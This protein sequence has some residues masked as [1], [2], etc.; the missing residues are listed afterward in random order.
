MKI[1]RKSSVS[2]ALV[3]ESVDV[4]I[5]KFHGC[6]RHTHRSLS[7]LCTEATPENYLYLLMLQ[8]FG[9]HGL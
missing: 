4:Q 8:T 2:R 6:L 5:D 9:T 7:D 1:Q 3:P